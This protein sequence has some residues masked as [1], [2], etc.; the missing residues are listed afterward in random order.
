MKHFLLSLSLLASLVPMQL[1]AAPARRHIINLNQ[2]DGSTIQAILSGD[3]YMSFYTDVQTGKCLVQ[4][5]TNGFWRTMSDQ[6]AATAATQWQEVSKQRKLDSN[7]ILYLGGTPNKGVVHLPVLLVDFAD[8]KYFEHGGTKDSLEM[9]LNKDDF[10]FVPYTSSKGVKYH[11]GSACN[12]FKTQSFGKFEPTFDIIGPI[13]LDKELA[14]YGQDNESIK[15]INYYELIREAVQKAMK[16]GYLNDAKKYDG[17]N[18]GNVDLLYILYAGWGQNDTGE[19]DQIWAKTAYPSIKTT[20]GTYVNLVSSS[21]ELSGKSPAGI[22]V[23]VHEFSH[24]LGLPDF[25]DTKYTDL[26]YGMDGWSVMDQGSYSGKGYIPTCYTTHERMQMGWMDEPDT[27]PTVGRDTLPPFVT[28]GKALI[29]RNPRNHDE[30]ITLENHQ[31]ASSIWEKCW[32]NGAYASTTISKG[33]LITH[34]D[35]D[36]DIWNGNTPNNDANHQRCSPLP[37]DGELMLYTY[38]QM[39]P[40]GF[41]ENHRND[42]FMNYTNPD[43]KILNGS[44]NPMCRW[45]TGDTIAINITNIEELKDGSLVLTFGN[46]VEPE[47]QDPPSSIQNLHSNVA[48]PTRKLLLS[49]GRISINGCDLMG[50]RIA[51]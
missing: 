30:Y 38:S 25:Y 2:P 23:L 29:L 37:A 46:Y 10:D 18:N 20:D 12:Y 34:V 17:D 16:A 35:Y 51:R 15:D 9:L 4:D 22:G 32:G 27:V 42:V 26:C 6:E 11:A 24:A 1:D 21:A 47:P 19:K 33:L 43:V 7:K 40:N 28:S 3:E 31:P 45:Y 14:Y 44:S 48:M 5:H 41:M 50:R 36:R 8:L 13:T 49:D 39:D